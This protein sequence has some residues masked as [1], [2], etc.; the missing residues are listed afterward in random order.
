[1][2]SAIARRAADSFALCEF[3]GLVLA[4]GT[5]GSFDDFPDASLD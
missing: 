2:P 4:G 3:L 5:A 1:M